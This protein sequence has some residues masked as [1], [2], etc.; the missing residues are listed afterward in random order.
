VGVFDLF[1]DGLHVA[2]RP[3]PPG[4]GRL[5]AVDGDDRGRVADG[6]LLRAVRAEAERRHLALDQLSLGDAGPLGRLAQ[7]RLDLLPD[8]TV[9]DPPAELRQ[10]GKRLLRLE[11]A[12]LADRRVGDLH[13]ALLGPPFERRGGVLRERP[14]DT[15]S[16]VG[17]DHARGPDQ[18]AQQHG[19][20]VD[21]VLVGVPAPDPT[22]PVRNGDRELEELSHELLAVIDA[23]DQLAGA[24]H[25]LGG[26]HRAARRL[27]EMKHHLGRARAAA[28]GEELPSA[29]A[30]GVIFRDELDAGRRGD[31]LAQAGQQPRPL[32]LPAQVGAPLHAVERPP[33]VRL[34]RRDVV[35]AREALGC[36]H[37]DAKAVEPRPRLSSTVRICE[38]QPDV[39][40]GVR[41]LSAGK[42]GC[43]LRRGRLR[44]PIVSAEHDDGLLHLARGEGGEERRPNRVVV[45]LEE[46]FAGGRRQRVPAHIAL[47]RDRLDPR[48][49]LLD[50]ATEL[51]ALAERQTAPAQ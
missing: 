30:P 49:S 10:G 50:A 43:Q 46:P 17:S 37:G 25:P 1:R 3:R 8:R 16:P 32:G 31:Q 28:F 35:V 19:V 5:V 23:A 38:Q 39:L 13:A 20:L 7:R 24:R 15:W 9:L 21:D 11:R 27:R 18:A 45:L 22:R 48:R 47:A 26:R 34:D 12:Q 6:H 4:Q 2:A 33:E 44:E 36:G 14:E 40:G 42:P 29:G 51:R 41:Q